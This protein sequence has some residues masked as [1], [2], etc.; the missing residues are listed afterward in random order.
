[1][2][3]FC[4]KHEQGKTFTPRQRDIIVFEYW[5]SNTFFFSGI[6]WCLNNSIE[7]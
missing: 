4:S 3:V 1:M 2:P 5:Y 6:K 7:Y